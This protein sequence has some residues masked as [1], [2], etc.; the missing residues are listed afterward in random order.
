MLPCPPQGNKDGTGSPGS[1]CRNSNDCVSGSKC[2]Q[3]QCSL[4]TNNTAI[5]LC[6]LTDDPIP[7]FVQV[8]PEKSD[9]PNLTPQFVQVEG[10][11]FKIVTTETFVAPVFR[12]DDVE[13]ATATTSGRGG[14]TPSPNP[15]VSLTSFSGTA[16]STS[17]PG[18][19]P[20]Q[21]GGEQPSSTA[22]Q[23]AATPTPQG[24]QLSEQGRPLTVAEVG[25]CEKRIHLG[26]TSIYETSSPRLNFGA[27][28]NI[29]DGNGFSFGCVQFT[30]ASSGLEVVQTYQRLVGGSTSLDRYI[31]GLD[32]A[33]KVGRQYS[34]WGV[35][36]GLDGFCEAVNALAN[37]RRW[38]QAQ[39]MVQ[40]SHYLNPAYEIA[41]RFGVTA[42]LFRGQIYDTCIQLGCGT[43]QSI[44]EGMGRVDPGN[45]EGYMRNYIRE[46][47]NRLWG[48]GPAYPGTKY[49]L[50]S[51][52]YAIDKGYLRFSDRVQVL[53]NGGY[54]VFDVTCG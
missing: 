6:R 29:N 4:I 24:P 31:W 54:S 18:P 11:T 35:T 36:D 25:E 41:Y 51:Y 32:N 14:A 16:T 38:Q 37:D 5:P 12:I 52:T 27:C 13:T 2:F 15:N 23:P 40:E 7:V 43:A 44:M 47:E 28:S 22:S 50:T 34:G 45:E 3:S 1:I 26:I 33:R 42:P 48:F 21:S 8:E 30:T 46:R 10:V 49:R 53:D 17:A 20:G 19:T 9:D 39:L